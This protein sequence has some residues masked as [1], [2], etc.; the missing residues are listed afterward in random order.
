M[1]G[2]VARWGHRSQR[3]QRGRDECSGQTRGAASPRGEKS[4]PVKTRNAR[5]LNPSVQPGFFPPRCGRGWS[6][7]LARKHST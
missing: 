1:H 3:A 7:S 6:P 5:G 2:R 4:P